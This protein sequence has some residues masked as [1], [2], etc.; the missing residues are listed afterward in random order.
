MAQRIVRTLG[1]LHGQVHQRPSIADL[2]IYVGR[3]PP[4]A[5]QRITFEQWL[6]GTP[7]YWGFLSLSGTLVALAGG[8]RL[9][10]RPGIPQVEVARWLIAI[11]MPAGAVASLRGG[12]PTV[13][14]VPEALEMPAGGPVEL[15]GGV[16]AVD[17]A[18]WVHVVSMVAGARAEIR[19]GAPTV[20][21]FF[22]GGLIVDPSFELDTGWTFSNSGAGCAAQRAQAGTP[23]G[24][25]PAH[26]AWHAYLSA[27]GGATN[28]PKSGSA[29]QIQGTSELSGAQYRASTGRLSL[30]AYVKSSL[31][32]LG[33]LTS[34]DAFV[35][36]LVAAYDGGGA[37]VG[38]TAYLPVMGAMYL[39]ALPG[40]YGQVSAALRTDFTMDVWQSKSADVRSFLDS[41]F[42]MNS[43]ALAN[44]T[45]VRFILRAQSNGVSTAKAIGGAF[46]AVSYS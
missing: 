44:I 28:A 12:V 40:G 20:L 34:E 38:Y 10:L 8:A 11:G 32:T 33:A 22:D 27:S 26:A 14:L 19:A 17:I 21:A 46:D 24:V 45:R 30:R 36:V 29:I 39:A 6:A 7:G 3:S 35:G 43:G 13:Y 31:T 1:D 4:P 2:G 23:S 16:P 41:V 42:T 5:E 15:R 9:D 25:T 37:Q 18:A